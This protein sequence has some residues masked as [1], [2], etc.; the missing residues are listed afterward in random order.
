MDGSALRTMTGYLKRK[1][2]R[3]WM[4]TRAVA[5]PGR[6]GVTHVA[7]QIFQRATKAVLS[8]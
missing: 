6:A 7:R 1:V 8:A 2:R 3:E 5:Q 4:D